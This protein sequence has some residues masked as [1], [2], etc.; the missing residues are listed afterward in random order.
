MVYMGHSSQRNMLWRH[1][2][3]ANN[4]TDARGHKR[5]V[6][7]LLAFLIWAHRNMRPRSRA[8]SR[9]KPRSA[10]NTVAGVHKCGYRT[11]WAESAIP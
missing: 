11:A 4:G 1:D 8:R 2:V 6:F 10:L 9:A 3:R 7:L 5:E